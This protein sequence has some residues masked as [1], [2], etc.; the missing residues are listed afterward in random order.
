[1]FMCPTILD[2]V[3]VVVVVSCA[4]V[5]HGITEKLHGTINLNEP[6]ASSSFSSA[7]DPLAELFLPRERADSFVLF[8]SDSICGRERERPELKRPFCIM[9]SHP[10]ASQPTNRLQSIK[11]SLC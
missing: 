8:A 2:I 3:V 5:A 9:S 11:F 7:G 1:M 6:I 10:P 4:I